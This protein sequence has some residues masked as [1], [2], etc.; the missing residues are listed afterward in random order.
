MKLKFL[1]FPFNNKNLLVGVVVVKFYI[2]NGSH[3]L[4]TTISLLLVIKWSL[5]SVCSIL[6]HE[7][8]IMKGFNIF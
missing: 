4:A 5:A 8:A 2:F 7:E 6:L 3:F 1:Y